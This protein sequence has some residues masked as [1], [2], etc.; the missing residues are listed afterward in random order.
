MTLKLEKTELIP[1]YYKI[2]PESQPMKDHEESTRPYLTNPSTPPCSWTDNWKL[3]MLQPGQ[4]GVVRC[5]HFC[6]AHSEW[7]QIL[8]FCR[9]IWQ[10]HISSCWWL[11]EGT[12]F[13]QYF[14]KRHS[15]G[16]FW[17]RSWQ[18]WASH[19][20]RLRVWGMILC[21]QAGTQR[22]RSHQAAVWLDL[23]LA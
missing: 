3:K 6:P 19:C 22:I 14:A 13:L 17:A 23:V 11:H 4:Q 10:C 9:Q 2:L 18:L 5:P 7:M 16:T 12:S 1:F 21:C 20:M 15:W 8:V